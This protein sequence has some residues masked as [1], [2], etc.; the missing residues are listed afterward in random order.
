MSMCWCKPLNK[1]AVQN[2]IPDEYL[3]MMLGTSP[4]ADLPEFNDE[5]KLKGLQHLR[6]CFYPQQRN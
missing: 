3:P 1:V 6:K 5:R 4:L 2:I